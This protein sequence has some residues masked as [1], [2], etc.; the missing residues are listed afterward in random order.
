M[1]L[2]FKQRLS[3]K[4]A[5]NLKNVIGYGISGIGPK[6]DGHSFLN[7]KLNSIICVGKNAYRKF[8]KTLK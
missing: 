5:K 7:F 1:S 4:E 8:N 6:L 2:F 3:A